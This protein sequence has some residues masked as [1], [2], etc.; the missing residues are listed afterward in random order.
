MTGPMR[1]LRGMGRTCFDSFSRFGTCRQ[2]SCS[3]GAMG[4]DVRARLGCNDGVR[5]SL[6]RTELGLEPWIDTRFEGFAVGVG[7]AKIVGKIHAV[8]VKVG[9]HNI[10]CA[11]TVRRRDTRAMSCY[12]VDR[13]SSR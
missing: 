7:K 5:S 11:I 1:A 12:A 10:N 13:R 8:K 9:T 3:T 6:G 4:A 2:G